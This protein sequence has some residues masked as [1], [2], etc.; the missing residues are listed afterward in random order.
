M[1]GAPTIRDIAKHAGVSF[2]SVSRV[3]NNERSV[4]PKMRR[5]VHA[6]IEKLGYFPNKNAR[7]LRQSSGGSTG[8]I[9]HLYGDAGGHYST[10][11][12]VGLLE[13]CRYFGYHLLV[14]EL[15]YKSPNFERYAKAVIG[16]HMPEGVVLA[17]PLTDNQVLLR[18]LDEAGIPYVKITPLVERPNEPSVRIDERAAAYQVAQHLLLFGHRRFGLI[19]GPDNHA[20]THLR[21]EGFCAAL[22]EFGVELQPNLIEN[23]EF[24]FMP[25]LQAAQR[26]LSQPDRP[27]AIFATSDEMA[28][29]VLKVAHDLKIRIP[30]ELSIVGF[31]DSYIAQMLNPPLTTV[32]QPTKR[33]AAAAADLLFTRLSPLG[34]G[35]WSSPAPHVILEYDFVLRTSTSFRL[36]ASAA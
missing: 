35:Q 11:I 17:A 12:Q 22:S 23:G 31:D 1:S 34:S 33:L 28:A 36:E 8:L 15:D 20:A 10:D 3:I 21:Q 24:R 19:R 4:S 6:A 2:K 26:L 13:R 7:S 32:R 16:Q 25:T 18:A 9:A 27:T 29:A 30:E 14:E 5:L